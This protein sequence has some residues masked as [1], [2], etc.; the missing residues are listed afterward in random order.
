MSVVSNIADQ[1]RTMLESA[2]VACWA[3]D[4]E[5]RISATRASGEPAAESVLSWAGLNS[6]DSWREAPTGVLSGSAGG[7]AWSLIP[8]WYGDRLVGAIGSVHAATQWPSRRRRWTS[9]GMLPSRSRT[10]GWWPR[11][12]V[13]STRSKPSPR[14][15]SSRPPSRIARAPRWPA[16]QPRTREHARRAVALRRQSS[17]PPG[18][19]RRGDAEG[20]GRRASAAAARAHISNRRQKD[21]SAARSA[22]RVARCI[23]PSDPGRGPAGRTA[24]GEDDRGRIRDEAPRH[25]P[26]G[27]GLGAHRPAR[28]RST[29][30][31]ES[32]R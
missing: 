14:S 12:A 25:R 18:S 24:R 30:S 31:S 4:T 6:E 23:R 2:G 29:R 27:P 1:A 3:F 15:R 8:L 19:R 32:G 28:A 20:S 21:A 10:P 5:G 7:Q 22:R 9:R 11:P 16:G 17:R 13:A 26:R